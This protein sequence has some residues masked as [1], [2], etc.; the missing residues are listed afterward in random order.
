MTQQLFYHNQGRGGTVVYK[1]AVSEIRFDFEFG[2]GNCVAII[3][4]PSPDT[5]DA[6]T[7]RALSEREE[8]VTF[9]A[10]QSLHD[11]VSQG[12][13]QISEQYIE[14]FRN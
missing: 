9:V 12:Y 11:Q 10:K 8:I 13:Y 5:W 14:L 6:A 7:N 3:F 4:I 1:D 2:G